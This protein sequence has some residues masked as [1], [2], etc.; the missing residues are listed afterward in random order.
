MPTL[1]A[2]RSAFNQLIHHRS[3]G[4]SLLQHLARRQTN[5]TCYIGQKNASVMQLISWCQ[6]LI[7]QKGLFGEACQLF[8]AVL[9]V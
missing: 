1:C 3:G 9:P 7:G 4:E 8:S 2:V 6:C 5:F